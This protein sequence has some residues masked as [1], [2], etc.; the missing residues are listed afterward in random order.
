ME[1][2]EF[3][4]SGAEPKAR[5][6]GAYL[7]E[8]VAFRRMIAPVLLQIMFWPAA[9]ASIY[10]SIWLIRQG[11]S[12]GWVPLIVGTLFVRVV[13]EALILFFRIFE[14]LSDI[15]AAIEAADPR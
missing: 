7:L 5:G 3:I 4:R 11:N 14:K 8:L 15:H 13:F 6:L 12:I 9:I 10:Y 2:Q 1:G